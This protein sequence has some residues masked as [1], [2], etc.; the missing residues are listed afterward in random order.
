MDKDTA[1]RKIQS[2]EEKVGMVQMFQ[3]NKTP[4][5]NMNA[6]EAD[7]DEEQIVEAPRS[8]TKNEESATTEQ[9]NCAREKALVTL[10]IDSIQLPFFSG[11]LTQWEAFK[12]LFE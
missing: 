5:D 6:D 4:S 11:D 8:S 3:V 10:K 12:D 1:D 2:L 7:V 9:T